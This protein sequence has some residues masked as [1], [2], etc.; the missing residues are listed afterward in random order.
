MVGTEEIKNA[1][2][3]ENF[4]RLVAREAWSMWRTLSGHTRVWLGVDD[5]IEEGMRWVAMVGIPQ[6]RMWRGSVG[7][8]ICTGVRNLFRDMR[9]YLRRTGRDDYRELSLDGLL[10]DSRQDARDHMAKEINWALRD[11]MASQK[12]TQD[13]MVVPVVLEVYRRASAPLR[14]EMTNWFLNTQDQGRLH[15]ETRTFR[16]ARD[17]FRG[18]AQRG[19]LGMEDCE[20]VL[21][22]PSCLDQLSREWRWVPFNLE[23][24]TPALR[25]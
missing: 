2:Q 5:L 19:G 4:R 9:S 13:C 21:K 15:L 23:C 14:R 3:A 18:L 10:A 11:T 22:S 12:V 25:V 8:F 7:T 17:E 16:L 6:W 24:P 1:Y 20:H